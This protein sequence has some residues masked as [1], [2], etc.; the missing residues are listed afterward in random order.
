MTIFRW[1]ALLLCT[2]LL[3]TSPVAAR[4]PPLSAASGPSSADAAPHLSG[5]V[6][7]LPLVLIRGYPFI[8]GEI[9][10]RR[11]KL[12]F[13]LGNVPA[14]TI[15]SHALPGLN[16]VVTGIG[17]F[18]SGQ[19]TKV[20]SFSE[21]IDLRLGHDLRFRAL[22]NVEGRDGRQLEQGITRDFLG[23]IGLRMFDGYVA[24]IDYH[25]KIVSFV[26]DSPSGDALRSATQSQDVIE[27]I[28]IPGAPGHP[29]LRFF[30]TS[31]G[32][33]RLTASVDTGFHTTAWLAPRDRAAMKR[34]GRLRANGRGRFTISGFRIGGFSL[35]S[36]EVDVIETKPVFAGFLPKSNDSI[37]MFGYEFFKLFQVSMNYRDEIMVIEKFKH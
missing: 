36:I 13:D 23:W 16:G 33:T 12:M 37:V 7:V 5:P 27:R 22:R 14:L 19:T 18:G 30:P 11:G 1:V 34:D 24:K 6:V 26:N 2:V 35:P 31:V 10:G 21:A 28:A 25:R 17:H 20:T 8:E 15:N 9:N 29:N 4:I 32:A 3:L